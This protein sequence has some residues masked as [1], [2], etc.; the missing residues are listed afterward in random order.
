MQLFHKQENSK[1]S[2]RSSSPFPHVQISRVWKL[3]IDVVNC[4]CR[5]PWDTSMD[6]SAQQHPGAF[7]A[8][9][10]VEGLVQYCGTG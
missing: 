3:N 5:R 8:V 6:P 2:G 10:A 9:V 4:Y 1:K 7:S